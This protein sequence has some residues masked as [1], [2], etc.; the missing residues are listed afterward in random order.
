MQGP[1]NDPFVYLY[2]E[3]AHGTHYPHSYGYTN[4]HGRT[5]HGYLESVF[6]GTESEVKR[7]I[8]GGRMVDLPWWQASPAVR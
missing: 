3:A 2:R 5:L 7:A 1:A 4:R 8:A 6:V